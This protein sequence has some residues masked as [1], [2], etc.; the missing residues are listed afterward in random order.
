L[1][2]LAVRAIARLA[3]RAQPVGFP[4]RV[5]STLPTVLRDREARNTAP[6]NFAD[7]VRPAVST[8]LFR[9]SVPERV[10]MT[11]PLGMIMLPLSSTVLELPGTRTRTV[12]DTTD[13]TA[14]VPSVGIGFGVS[15]G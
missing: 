4:V 15:G 10:S 11:V 8:A 5:T 1:L 13:A 3:V 6:R 9:A 2:L 12:P 7:C 14:V